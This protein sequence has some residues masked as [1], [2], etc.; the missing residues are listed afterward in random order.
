M[1][2]ARRKL[3]PEQVKFARHCAALRENAKEELAVIPTQKALA[4]IWG[5]SQATV[6]H[7][8][9]HNYQDVD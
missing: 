5:V 1:T 3:T 6:H 7:A 9:W 2:D 8:V 4:D